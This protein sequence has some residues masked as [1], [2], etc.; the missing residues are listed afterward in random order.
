MPSM[1]EA[2]ENAVTTPAPP[3]CRNC[4]TTLSGDYCSRC[5][6][7]ERDLRL[8]DVAGEA[9]EDVTDLDSRLWR[10]LKG[11]LLRPGA[12]T[13]D[14]IGGRRARYVPPIRLYLVVSFLV[15]LVVSQAG[16]GGIVTTGPE[17]DPEL[18]EQVESGIYIPRTNESGEQELLTFREYLDAEGLTDDI[19]AMPAWFQAAVERMVSNAELLQGDPDDFTDQ[20]FQRL[21]QV[22]FFLLPIF[23]LLLSLFYLGSPFH[24]L[25]HLIFSVH[26][27]TVAFLL[28]LL[29][30][31]AG[32]LLPGDYGGVVTMAL[33]IYLPLALRRAYGSG[34][35]A[36]VLKGVSIGLVYYFVVALTG[37]LVALATLALL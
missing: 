23:A 6:Q 34:P 33:F 24:Y 22:M 21:P 32:W 11:L 31:P 37:T 17:V 14:Y 13:A 12:V 27:H 20:M 8:A 29:M 18:L 10:T 7:R 1:E 16:T 35:V 19:E 9:L 25:Q 28:F 26:Y 4:G 36:A 2:R 3:T 5:G 15:F 30:W